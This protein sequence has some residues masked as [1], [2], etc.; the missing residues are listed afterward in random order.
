MVG[1]RTASHVIIYPYLMPSVCIYTEPVRFVV[2]PLEAEY[3]CVLISNLCCLF[4]KQNN[5]I[6]QCQ[7]RKTLDNN[8][9]VPCYIIYNS[10]LVPFLSSLYPVVGFLCSGLSYLEHLQ[11]G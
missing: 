3:V 5:I 8:I 1:F 11:A 2:F 7:D 9:D 6:L 10:Y 4:F